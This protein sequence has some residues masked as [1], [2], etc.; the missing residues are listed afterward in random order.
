VSDRRNADILDQIVELAA[1]TT[2]PHQFGK[3]V[4]DLLL[5]E[6]KIHEAVYD[7]LTGK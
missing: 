2:N 1:Q 6:G 5:A 3:E 4:A 7:V